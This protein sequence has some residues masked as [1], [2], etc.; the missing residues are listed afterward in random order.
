MAHKRA[1]WLHNPYNLGSRM[2]ESR[3]EHQKGPKN[4]QIGCITPAVWGVP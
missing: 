4:L 3:G 2:L 1:D